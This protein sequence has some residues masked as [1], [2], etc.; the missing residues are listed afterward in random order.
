[1]TE[2]FQHF[3]QLNIQ[4]GYSVG[5][6]L[7]NWVISI[8]GGSPEAAHWLKPTMRVGTLL[9]A[10][11]GFVKLIIYSSDWQLCG[12][13]F[14]VSFCLIRPRQ[15]LGSTGREESDGERTMTCG[16][17]SVISKILYRLSMF[18]RASASV[19]ARHLIDGDVKWLDIIYKLEQPQSPG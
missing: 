13:S 7:I 8:V 17:L 3:S 15:W 12:T 18:W 14:R 11:N 10:N 1:M 4:R 9:P 19:A 5:S 16:G 2:M 6:R